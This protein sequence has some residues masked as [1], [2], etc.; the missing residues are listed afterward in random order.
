[1]RSGTATQ[2]IRA[3]ICATPPS[4]SSP[5]R[6]SNPAAS[7]VLQ[8]GDG[9]V[10]ICLTIGVVALQCLALTVS[11][12]CPAELARALAMR[13]GLARAGWWN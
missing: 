9:A 8:Q 3:A 13:R 12:L 10:R 5:S 6:R 7:T 1:M 2:Q 11:A 4:A